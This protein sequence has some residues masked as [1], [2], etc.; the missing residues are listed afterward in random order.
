MRIHRLQHLSVLL[1]LVCGLCAAQEPAAKILERIG[2]DQ[3]L[4][5]ALPLELTFRDETG[6]QRALSTFFSGRPVILAPVYYR[7]PMLCTLVLNGVVK[8]LKTMSLTPGKDF[9]VLAVSFNPHETPELA[10]QKKQSALQE[11]GKPGSEAGWHFLTGDEQ[12]IR[13][14]M[15]AIGFRYTFDEASN[16]YFH[17][18]GIVVLTPSGR[19]S[20]Y[21]YGAEYL[22][23]DL[24][25]GLVEASSG[26]IGNV[27]DQALL[28]CFQYNPATGKYGLL[29]IRTLQAA[30]TTL[31]AILVIFISLSLARER[32]ARQ[33]LQPLAREGGAP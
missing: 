24:R 8:S 15:D 19:V 16:E 14:L 10:A 25:L 26:K 11:Y 6:Q 2:F 1:T 3:K 29:I 22:P 17:A 18:S 23:R 31:V 27:V 7:C 9:E 28:Y 13:P 20:R 33:S 12:S 4:D 5:A 32:R 21:F 30:G